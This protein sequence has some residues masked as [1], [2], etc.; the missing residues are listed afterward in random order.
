MFNAYYALLP[1]K[2]SER[3]RPNG[4]VR[5]AD[6]GRADGRYGEG[7][8]DGY[9]VLDGS[10]RADGGTAGFDRHREGFLAR[11]VVFSREAFPREGDVCHRLIR[12]IDETEGARDVVSLYALVRGDRRE[13][14]VRTP[15]FAGRRCDA[16][17]EGEA[18]ERN[19]EKEGRNA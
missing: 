6:S 17:N 13:N 12:L 18:N 8:S 4:A 19:G 11:N 10:D 5:I 16:G 3:I 2:P 15:R 14:A 7:I 1:L 9:A